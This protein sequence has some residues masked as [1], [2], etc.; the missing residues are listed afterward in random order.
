MEGSNNGIETE[1][2]IVESNA[3]AVATNDITIDY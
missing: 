2:L 3:S 1:A